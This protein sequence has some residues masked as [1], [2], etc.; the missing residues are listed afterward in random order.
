MVVGKCVLCSGFLTGIRRRTP[1]ASP[2][3]V[4]GGEA[5][6][7][8]LAYLDARTEAGLHQVLK[9]RIKLHPERKQ[10]LNAS[11][12]TKLHQYGSEATA[13]AMMR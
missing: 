9:Q 11:A 2:P 13:S 12:E 4:D 6:A 3:I 8:A 1:G 7:K 5:K 10:K